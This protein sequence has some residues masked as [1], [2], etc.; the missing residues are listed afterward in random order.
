MKI[1]TKSDRSASELNQ[2]I[3]KHLEELTRATDQARTSEE[4]L[5]Y[6]NF[7][8][9][10]HQYSAGNIW[11][12]MLSKPDASYVAG[13]HKWKSMGRWVRKGEHGI[14]ILAPIFIKV[15]VDKG[16]KEEQ[17]LGF[18]T[19]YV[20]DVSQTQGKPLPPVPDWKSPEKNEEL[21]KILIKFAK[22]KGIEVSIEELPGECQGVSVSQGGTIVL[23]PEAGTKTLIHELGHELLHQNIARWSIES[24]TMELEAESVAF[25]VAKHF[26]FNDL[27]SPNYIALHKSEAKDIL[28]CMERITRTAQ[29]IIEYVDK[30]ANNGTKTD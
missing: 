13:F 7:C 29:E 10:F 27:N 16:L 25:V 18:R 2:Q 23:S 5:R 26:G 6:L 21:S 3:V 14:P 1:I 15:E 4:M 9:K 24:I 11:L 28:G 8:A 22:S 17:L 30:E 19:V 20:F 12:I